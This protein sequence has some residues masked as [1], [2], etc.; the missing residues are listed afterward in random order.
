MLKYSHKQQDF[1]KHLHLLKTALC[2]IKHDWFFLTTTQ[3][4]KE[5][6]DILQYSFYLG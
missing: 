1:Q 2:Y 5:L 6:Q 3:H 4:I